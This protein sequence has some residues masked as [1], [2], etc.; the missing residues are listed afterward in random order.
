MRR[1][2][3][4]VVATHAYIGPS[5]RSS[6]PRGPPSPRAGMLPYRARASRPRPQGFGGALDA[7]SLSVPGRSTSELLRTPW[8]GGCFRANVLAVQAAGPRS[9]NLARARG[10]WPLVRVLPLSSAGIST[11]RLTPG[12]RR[13]AFGVRRGLIGGEALA[14][15]RSLYLRAAA[16][17]LPLKAFRGVRAISQLDWPFTPTHSSSEG[18]ST[19]TGSVLQPVAPGLQP[20]HG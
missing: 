9:A 8:T 19:P 2:P 18:F 4:G 3:A 20:G 16:P 13:A 1:F 10:P 5:R 7:R 11:R 17:R 6:R 14:P 15:D 12:D